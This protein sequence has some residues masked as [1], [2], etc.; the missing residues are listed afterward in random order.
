MQAGENLVFHIHKR[1]EEHMIEGD[2]EPEEWKRECER[3]EDDLIEMEKELAMAKSLGAAPNGDGDFEECRNHVNIIIDLCNDI[4]EASHPD[5]RKF[6]ARYFEQ[7][8]D[9]LNFIRK[10]ERRINE[11]NAQD[12]SKLNSIASSKKQ[13]A[14]DLRGLIESVKSLDQLLRN[15]LGDL[16]RTNEKIEELLKDQSGELQLKKLKRAIGA[17]KKEIKVFGMNEA[18]MVNFLFGCRELKRGSHHLYDAVFDQAPP[19]SPLKD[20]EFDQ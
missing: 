13:I 11:N 15:L 19:D 8:D 4:K 3:V 17:V 2:I 12:I 7:L 14:A 9:E 1:E 6:F 18:V 20:E 10:Q 5:V 16:G